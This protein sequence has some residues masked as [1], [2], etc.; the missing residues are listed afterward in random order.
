M[1]NKYKTHIAILILTILLAN[2]LPGEAQI[3]KLAI[4]H[5]NRFL[6]KEDGSP[7]IWIGETNWFFA[8]LHPNVIDSILDKRSAQGFTVMLVSCREK[9]ING[10]GP[11][12]IT[13]PNLDWWNYL[14]DYISKCAERGLYV[15]IT[16]GWWGVIKKNSAED[17]FEYGKWVGQRYKDNN[18][19]IWLTLGESGSYNRKEE[20]P[21]T[22]TSALVQGIKLG[23][24]G[25][26]LLTVHADYQRGTSITNDGDLCDFN[27][28]QTS[29]WC[30][31]DNL[32]RKDEREWTVW[33]AIQF[34]YSKLYNGS[35]KPTIDLEAW[36]ENNKDFCGTTP[37]II[38]RRAYF[39]IF[40]GAFGHNYGAGG[41]W[42]GLTTQ[43]DCSKNAL[44][45]LDYPGATQISHVS[46]FL[47]C[48]GED[49]LKMI[50]DQSIIIEG[51]SD[52]YDSHIQS[53]VSHDK[54]FSLIY[55]ASDFPYKLDLQKMNI[56]TMYYLWYHPESNTVRSKVTSAK[57]RSANE[58]TFDPPGEDGSGNDWILV[59]GTK[60]FVSNL[61]GKINNE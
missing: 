9:M 7:F 30:C 20:I 39:T 57:N 33:E 17:L 5:N 27:N 47:H 36:Y 29:Q 10:R 37:Y 28:W 60:E 58:M 42:D 59:I 2:Y 6:T 56:Q 55:S 26:K 38:R 18:N 12:E 22:K 43:M 15:G 14:D 11:G 8:K 16:L 19:I 4:S 23:D 24:S 44:S 21:S 54:S 61:S 13:N 53:V 40:A 49:F 3:Q 32:P 31:P 34:D 41:I 46:N 35:P 1:K 50:P 51:N 48:L 52:N 25:N 45:A